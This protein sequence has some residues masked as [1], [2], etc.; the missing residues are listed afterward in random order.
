MRKVQFAEVGQMKSGED[1][2]F[3]QEWCFLLSENRKIVVK[4]AEEAE[5]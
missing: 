2:C 4:L 3:P 1:F 5:K